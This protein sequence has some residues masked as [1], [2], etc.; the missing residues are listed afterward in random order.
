MSVT[1]SGIVTDV[2]LRQLQNAS[3]PIMQVPWG[4]TY[5]PVFDTGQHTSLMFG[6]LNSTPSATSKYL[7]S[8]DPVIL[9]K[10]LQNL[11]G[12]PAI[13]DTLP[14]SV[15]DVRPRPANAASSIQFT[16]SEIVTDVRLLQYENA[17]SPMLVTL[18][19]IVTEVSFSHSENAELPII[20]TLSGIVTEVKFLQKQ[21]A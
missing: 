2:R 12:F 7:F 18:P 13:Y 6:L 8:G 9:V 14:G 11:N 19:G 3:L 1:P 15:T 5:P 16:P 21:N 4:I 10:L 17:A 20:V